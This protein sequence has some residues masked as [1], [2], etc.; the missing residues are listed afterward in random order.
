MAWW[1]ILGIYLIVLWIIGIIIHEID[2]LRK[3][4]DLL[5]DLSDDIN[6]IK[7]KLGLEVVNRTEDQVETSNRKW[8]QENV[9]EGKDLK[10]FKKNAGRIFVGKYGWFVKSCIKDYPQRKICTNCE[11]AYSKYTDDCNACGK[12]LVSCAEFEK[13]NGKV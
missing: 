7:E 10:W 13:Q 8:I 2:K 4:Y 11:K 5:C 3:V 6:E 12:E 9:L 1:E